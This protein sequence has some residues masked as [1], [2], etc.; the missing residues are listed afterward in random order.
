[1]VDDPASALG[2][3]ISEV[4]NADD[5]MAE[6]L[7]QVAVEVSAAT[8]KPI[9][10]GHHWTHLRGREILQ[11]VAAKGVATIEGT[12]NIFLAI[13]NAFAYR[14]FRALPP[15]SPP[16]LPE[17]GIVRRWRD[18]L[19][20]GAALD[21]A[22][23]L[24]LLADFGIATPA[25]VPVGSTAEAAAAAGRLGFPLAVKT[26]APGILHKS[27]VDGV[28]LGLA[29]VE[30]VQ[31]AYEELARRLGPQALIA[32]MAPPGTELAL[33]LIRDPQFGPLIVVGAGG[34][35]IEVLQDR[36]VLMP[37]LDRLRAG[38]AVD[39]LRLR[40][41]LGGHRGRPGADLDKLADAVARFSVLAACLGDLIGELDVNP[42]IAGPDG[43]VAVD[44]LVLPRSAPAEA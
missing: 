19:H 37:P 8:Q 27:D 29:T 34:T 14:D 35:L 33:G 23:A 43:A 1:V 21:E 4:S 28:R 26:A 12:E 10:L 7:A 42:L 18:R 30:A 36:Q 16:P 17:A 5:P 20:S 3:F 22:E 31:E 11:R 40:P 15:L 32:R 25:L 2:V 9:L 24:A 6:E 44:A 39:R 38:G 41:L 13:R